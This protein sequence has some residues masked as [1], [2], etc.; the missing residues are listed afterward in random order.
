MADKITEYYKN[1]KVKREYWGN[2][3]IMSRLDGPAEI[4]YYKNGNKEYEHW[5][6]N[7]CLCRLDG[8]AFISYN[9]DED[10]INES[11]HDRTGNYHRLD[12]PAIIWYTNN[13][14]ES[15]DEHWYI[16]GKKIDKPYNKWPLTKEQQIEMKLI[17]G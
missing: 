4:T 7:D 2:N 12:G 3:R 14:N 5:I 11:W 8:P 13:D 10:V 1:G 15:S 17:H 9:K 16:H 6:I